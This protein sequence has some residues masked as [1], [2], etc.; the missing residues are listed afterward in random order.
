MAQR[1]R[2]TGEE[3]GLVEL[4]KKTHFSEKKEAWVHAD[5][6]IRHV[7]HQSLC[8]F[9]PYILNKMWMDT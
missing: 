1:D 3:L 7:R 4:Y 2:A 5:A 6:E 9:I 8:T